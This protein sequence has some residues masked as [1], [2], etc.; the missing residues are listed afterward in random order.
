MVG[1]FLRAERIARTGR[2]GTASGD[3]ITGLG[4]QVGRETP[5]ENLHAM[6]DEAKKLGRRARSGD[7]RP[8]E[9]GADHLA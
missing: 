4:A 3:C 2:S 1:G 5:E 8:A 7:P 6:I 9:S